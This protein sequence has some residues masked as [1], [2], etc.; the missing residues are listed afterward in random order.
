[1]TYSQI[2]LDDKTFVDRMLSDIHD[3]VYKSQPALVYNNW[4]ERVERRN[5]IERICKNHEQ[6]VALGLEWAR[7]FNPSTFFSNWPDLLEFV[8]ETDYIRFSFMQF[9]NGILG[10]LNQLAD[11]YQEL[12]SAFSSRLRAAMKNVTEV[13]E[14]YTEPRTERRKI[15]RL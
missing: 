12:D 15:V 5:C 14:N 6:A 9:C 11:A 2:N 3:I 13:R 1:M 10:T 8:Q 7:I 4:Y